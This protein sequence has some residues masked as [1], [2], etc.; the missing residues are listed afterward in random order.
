MIMFF[1]LCAHK[2]EYLYSMWTYKL[3]M[4]YT[5]IRKKNSNRYFY[6]A[7]TARRGNK[8]KKV[9]IYLGKNLAASELSDLEKKSDI[10]L[11][12]SNLPK[13]IE[14]IQKKILPILRK[15]KIK[16]A[17]IFGSYAEGRPRKD[18]DIDILI[19]PTKHLGFGFT[20]LEME[21]SKK[22][23][24]KVDLV[25]YKG[26]SPYLKDKIMGQEIRII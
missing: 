2:W 10:R 3:T 17:G 18:S 8:F 20:G 11:R 26:L 5:E 9:R 15:N 22:L 13:D 1:I 19:A 23:G 21:L 14:K 12:S 6:R 7:M 4:A 25:S 16:R 24:K